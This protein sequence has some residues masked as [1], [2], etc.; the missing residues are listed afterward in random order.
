MGI[1]AYFRQIKEEVIA[2]GIAEGIADA[3]AKAEA[4]GEA[5]GVD[6]GIAKGI[7]EGR[8]LAISELRAM[9]RHEA[10]ALL[11]RQDTNTDP[12][13]EPE[14]GIPARRQRPTAPGL[15][16]PGHCGMPDRR[17]LTP[18]QRRAPAFRSDA[19]PARR[20][21]F[22]HQFAEKVA[23][24][25]CLVRFGY[26]VQ[27]ESAAHDAAQRALVHHFHHIGHRAPGCVRRCP[28]DAAA[29]RAGWTSPSAS[30]LPEVTPVM[31]SRPSGFKHSIFSCHT[32][33]P[34]QSNT[35]STPLPSV[36][37]STRALMLSVSR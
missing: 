18:A 6:K 19:A 4:R 31:T 30:R 9:P 35:T 10:L 33:A 8:E 13:A 25:H 15:I 24:G 16:A 11:E 1:A 5:R 28:S 20:S 32:S 23:V 26:A 7:S 29:G 2:E 12:D 22:N 37:S 14:L 34:T 17:R 21:V 3:E 27:R 36:N